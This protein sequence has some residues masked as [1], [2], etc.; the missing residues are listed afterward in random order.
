MKPL[1]TLTD[2]WNLTIEHYQELGKGQAMQIIREIIYRLG[3]SKEDEAK[4][5]ESLNDLL[6]LNDDEEPNLFT[7]DK[8]DTDML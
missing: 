8:N 1:K 4:L 7:L 6:G 5:V 2:I 3:A